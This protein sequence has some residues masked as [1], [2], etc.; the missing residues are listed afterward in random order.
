[1]TQKRAAEARALWFV[2]PRRVELRPVPVPRPGAGEVLVRTTYSGVSAGTELLAFRGLLDPEMPLD[3][4]IGALGGTFRYPFR[5][6]YSCVGVI[7]EA[8]DAAAS[9]GLTVGT[10]VFSFQ[11][12]AERFVAPASALV[13]LGAVGD[14][15]AT[16]FPLVETAL[17]ITLDAGAVLEEQVVV[18]GLGAV[19]ALT[20]LVLQRAGA[21]VVGVEPRE[22]R[23]ALLGELGLQAVPPE[24]LA[25]T[26][27]RDGGPP[28]VP[29]IVEASGNPAALRDAL[30][31][32]AHEGTALVASWYGTQD[33]A[34]PLGAEFHRR[35]LAL[36]STQVSTIPARLS[37]RWTPARRRDAAARLM[38]VLPLSAL[39][40]P[41]WATTRRHGPSRHGDP[42]PRPAHH[43]GR[44]G[45]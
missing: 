18:F 5:Y 24:G 1:M 10:R 4:T 21:R 30:P 12:H 29:L 20:G 37:G 44:G 41:R 32:L 13:P 6:G 16:M 17:Q 38:D 7:E 40:T 31:F 23:R 9:E 3:E 34:L 2:E 26:L 45:T 14:R 28:A 27:A 36:R 15:E 43:A 11:P 35:R 33:V 25:D 19:G 42:G 22:W 39:A 8:D